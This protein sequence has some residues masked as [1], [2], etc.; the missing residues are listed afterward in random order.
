MRMVV[1]M[2]LSLLAGAA[3]GSDSPDARNGDPRTGRGAGAPR[4]RRPLEAADGERDDVALLGRDP[5]ELRERAGDRGRRLVDGEAD[6][7]QLA[8]PDLEVD[9]RGPPRAVRDDDG[10]VCVA[11]D[12]EVVA[13][14]VGLRGRVA[15]DRG[16]GRVDVVDLP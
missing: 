6:R 5:V 14:G 13:I 15:E 11:V 16:A 2:R 7:R 8:G 4:T 9:G 3:E 12:E 1:C 10:E